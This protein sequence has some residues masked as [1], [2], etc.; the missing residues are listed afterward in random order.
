M[1]DTAPS[2]LQPPARRRRSQRSDLEAELARLT[3]VSYAELQSHW[4]RLFRSPPPRKIGRDT[5]ELGVAWKLQEKAL[6]GLNNT[7][8][9]TLAA[10]AESLRTTGDLAKPRAVTLKP[11]A[12]LLREWNG[13]T[14]S[15]LVLDDG[16]Q[17]RGR[18]WR[19]LSAIAREI[20]GTRWSGPRFFGLAGGGPTTAKPIAAS[21]A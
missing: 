8:R 18:P 14:H 1:L 13:E 5:L 6:G 17:W 16:F 21:N 9:R 19:S 4:R 12:R 10:H 20:T 3:L 15:V 11:G 7:T 2:G